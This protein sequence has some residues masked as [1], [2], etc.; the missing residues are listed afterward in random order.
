MR[1]FIAVNLTARDRKKI[2]SAV[3]GVRDSDFPVRWLEPADYHLTLKF[4]GTVDPRQVESLTPLI[5]TVARQT[6]SFELKIQGVGAFPTIRRP[7]VVWVGVDPSPALRCLKQDLEWAMS[8]GGYERET[9]AFHPHLTIGRADQAAGAGAFRGMDD[10]AAGLSFELQ[11]PLRSVD[12]MRSHL[13]KKGSRY[14]VL[15]KSSL[16]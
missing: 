10:A 11:A 15:H 14:E 9:R 2:Y 12:L 8:S 16:G 7:D 3:R 5:D 1:L 4:L 13:S 6:A